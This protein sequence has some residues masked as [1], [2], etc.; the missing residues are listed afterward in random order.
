MTPTF[1][2]HLGQQQPRRV[3]GRVERVRVVAGLGQPRASLADRRHEQAGRPPLRRQVRR[4]RRRRRTG[5]RRRLSC[6]GC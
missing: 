2:Q 4:R 6:G 1:S 5:P 3:L